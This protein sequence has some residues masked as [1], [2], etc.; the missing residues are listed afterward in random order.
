MAKTIP[1]LTDATTV[2]AADELIIQQGG[3][4]KRATGAELAKG[5][6]TINGTVNVKD[7][8]AV[9]DGVADDTAAIQAAFDYA[10]SASVAVEFTNRA[11][12]LLSSWTAYTNTSLL[13]LRGNGATLR[14]PS[15]TVDFLSPAANFKISDCNFDR[16][17]SVV[18]R[19]AASTGSFTDVSFVFNLCTNCNG[20]VFNIERPIEQ[21]RICDNNFDTCTGGYAV[22]IG[23]NSYADQDTWIR[24]WVCNNRFRSLSA[25]GSTATAA[26]LI[27]GREVTISGNKIDGISQTGTGEAWGIYTKVRYGQVVD[28]YINGVNAA[29]NADNQGINIKGV[30]R[31]VTSVPQGFANVVHGNIVNNITN[32]VSTGGKGG[33]IRAQTDDVIISCNICEDCGIITDESTAYSNV[34]ISNNL[35]RFASPVVSGTVGISIDG[36]GSDIIADANVVQNAQVGIRIRP[37][38]TS[39]TIEDVQVTRNVINGCTSNI[40]FRSF[41]GCTVSRL[42][43]ESN[44]VTGGT[45]GILDDTT[46]GTVSDLRIRWN[47]VSRAS[48]PVSGTATSSASIASENTGW[49]TASATWDPADIAN[50]SS[51]AT[52]FTVT[53]AAVGDAVLASFSNALG[54]LALTAQVSAAN[55]VEVRLLNNSGGSVDLASGTVR[56]RVIKGI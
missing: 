46:A 52:T 33:G 11:T 55:T 51:E 8:G 1:Q 18:E 34:F 40:V 19:L 10:Q 41:S 44:V 49:L 24:G 47:D 22:R 23:T 30:T 31:S 28:N 53:G 7:F 50:G 26:I 32:G 5:L 14:G 39:S 27:Y 36:S 3:I 54:G 38:A 56:V 35:V 43:I 37:A 13:I 20:Q 6:N 2:N 25:S 16:W 17:N 42:A 29:D 4:T 9:G 21:Y 45:H 48:T 15:A 12:Y